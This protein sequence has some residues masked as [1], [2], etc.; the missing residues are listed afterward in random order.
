[1]QAATGGSDAP[2]R[3]AMNHTRLADSGGVEGY[4]FRLVNALLARGHAVD[5]FCARMDRPIEHP[6]FRAFSVPQPRRPTSL[7]VALFARRSARAIAQAARATP[8][9]VVQGFGRTWYQTVYRDGSGCH[10]DYKEAYLDRVKRRGWRRTHY[11]LFPTD[12][13]VQAIERWRYVARPPR[14]VIAIS[15][16]VREQILRRYALPPERVRVLYNGIDLERHHPRLA[17]AGR[18]QLLPALFAPDARGD[19]VA[20]PRALVFVGSDFGRKGL[21]LLIDALAELEGDASLAK[22]RYAVAVVGRDHREE[23]WQQRAARRGVAARLR[24]LGYRDDVPSLLAGSDGLV[25]PSWFDAFGNVVAEALACGAP[26]V[27]SPSCGGAEW[28]RDGENGFVAT[29]QEPACL[30]RA[31]RALLLRDDASSL[32]AMARRTA[33]AY[34]WDA[35]VDALLALYRESNDAEKL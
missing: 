20:A 27:A 32:R 14:L 23:Q 21:D 9:D 11:R 24:F 16:L 6:A 25:L 17:E 19:G 33:L 29:R 30:A 35:H 4:I 12:R 5:Y 8:Y 28:I 22:R 34:P 10:A 7:R 2:L 18:A 31:L 26:V 3:I 1:M 13:A 15:R